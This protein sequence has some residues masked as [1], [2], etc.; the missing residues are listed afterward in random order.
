MQKQSDATIADAR[1]ESDTLSATGARRFRRALYVG[2]V[3][4]AAGGAITWKLVAK[5]DA[6]SRQRP[7]EASSVVRLAPATTMNVPVTLQALGTVTSLSTVTIKTQIAGKLLDFAVTEG[8][9]VNKGGFIAQIDPT[10]Y[11]VTL[12]QMSAALARDQATLAAAQFDLARYEKLLKQDS[13]ASQQVDT[14]RA[15]VKSGTATVKLDEANVANARVNLDYCHITAL[16]SGR[17]GLRLVDPGNYVQPS[18]ATGIVTIV[19]MK[20]IS[21][22]FSMSEDT[23]PEYLANLR[24]GNT[25]PVLAY[26]RDGTALLARGT[27]STIDNQIDSTTGTVKLRAVF[28]NDDEELF[29]NQ[30]VNVHLITKTLHGATVVPSSAVQTG[31]QGAFVYLASDNSSVSVRPVKLGPSD[32]N[33]VTVTEGLLPGDDVVIDGV[34]RLRDGASIRVAQTSATDA[35]APKQRSVAK[36]Q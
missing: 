16:A 24:A 2:L 34:D 29:P 33:N 8:Q 3:V 14:Q 6:T 30:F 4:L 26:N 15:T 35:I 12:D 20:P 27:L 17:I 18:D 22:I 9:E 28:P 32:G 11:Q 13:I 25:L 7:P 19:Q 1:S 23:I 5:H 21:V 10:P 31:A 36:Q